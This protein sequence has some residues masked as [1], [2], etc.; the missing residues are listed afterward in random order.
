MA[1]VPAWSSARRRPTLEAAMYCHV[2]HC[3]Q[4]YQG[5]V[6]ETLRVSTSTLEKDHGCKEINDTVD[7]VIRSCGHLS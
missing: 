6:F 7:G 1:I 5:C 2:A 4:E 3:Q